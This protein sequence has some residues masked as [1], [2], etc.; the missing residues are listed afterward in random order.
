MNV[1]AN[2]NEYWGYSKTTSE[3][4]AFFIED[5]GEKIVYCYNHDYNQPGSPD[6][7]SENKTYYTKTE[8]YLDTNDDLM[9]VYGK[10]KKKEL[11]LS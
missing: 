8:G 6:K 5:G 7:N 10:E 2:Q 9:N 11:Q 1:F 4:T 3:G